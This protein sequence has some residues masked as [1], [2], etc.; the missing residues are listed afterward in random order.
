MVV[1]NFFFGRART[2]PAIHASIVWA[3][4]DVAASRRGLEDIELFVESVADRSQVQNW[5]GDRKAAV[6]MAFEPD[7]NDRRAEVKRLFRHLQRIRVAKETVEQARTVDLCRQAAETLEPG[8]DQKHAV[9]PQQGAI[10]NAQEA[11]RRVEA[12]ERHAEVDRAR[13]RQQAQ[14]RGYEMA[15][16]R[17]LQRK[18]APGFNHPAPRALLVASLD[19]TFRNALTDLEQLTG[20]QIRGIRSQ[21]GLAGDCGVRNSKM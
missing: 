9:D 4:A 10:R 16:R 17:R 2:A 20:S 6:E 14:A 5:S 18:E 13:K 7:Q 15:C 21:S 3:A 11:A 19:T 1:A 8:K 12:R